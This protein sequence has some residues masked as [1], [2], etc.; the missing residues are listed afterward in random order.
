MNA[1]CYRVDEGDLD[2]MANLFEQACFGLV[3]DPGGL[4]KGSRAV[5]AMLDNVTLYNGKPLTKHVI[6]N[7]QIDVDEA[8]DT[9]TATS[10]LTVYQAV[11][12]NFPLQAIFIGFYA[13]SFQR[14]EK[15]WCF[16]SRL[17]SP[18]LIGDLSHHRA[19]M[20]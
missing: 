9:A 11:P 8:S 1:Y 10:Y 13:D 2:G 20:V 5:R 17:I 7:V 16:K 12:P 18:D 14:I 6:S 19:D 3:G 15:Q 4:M